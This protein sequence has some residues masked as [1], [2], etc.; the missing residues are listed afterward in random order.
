LIF[1]FADYTFIPHSEAEAE[2][3]TLLI[4]LN[5]VGATRPEKLEINFPDDTVSMFKLSGKTYFLDTTTDTDKFVGWS[6][7]E[8]SCR[9]TALQVLVVANG[10]DATQYPRA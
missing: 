1:Q 3:G 2:E 7:L 8:T 5:A 6:Y 9:G 4:P 10:Y